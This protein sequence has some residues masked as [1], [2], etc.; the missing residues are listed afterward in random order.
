MLMDHKKCLVAA[1]VLFITAVGCKT[2][3]AQGAVCTPDGGLACK[4]SQIQLCSD[5]ELV[6]VSACPGGCD[7]ASGI[8]RCKANNGATLSPIGAVC[9]EGM[10]LC[11]IGTETP[12]LLSCQSGRMALAAT[13]PSGCID[14]GD[15]GG[16]FCL[17]P[18]GGLRFHAGF[19]C[20]GFK[21][22][23]SEYACGPDGASLLECV[24]GKLAVSKERSCA[25]C[26]QAQA[27]GAVTCK[28]VSGEVVDLSTGE[29]L[30]TL[31]KPEESSAQSDTP[32]KVA[33]TP[34]PGPLPSN[35]P[36]SQ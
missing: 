25:T 15:N 36:S 8:V 1:G 30:P 34:P 20:P 33:P 2:Q 3:G 28:D 32:S 23:E 17:G 26:Y 24:D 13:C 4:D 19:Q 6:V 35:L 7:D 31:A 27:T 21:K 18:K 9:R 10:T 14:E 5:G 16:L 12:S 29:S 22:G 11:G